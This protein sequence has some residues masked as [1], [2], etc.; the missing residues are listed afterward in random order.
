MSLSLAQRPIMRR[1]GKVMF[2]SAAPYGGA[3]LAFAVSTAFSL[4]L[5]A[6]AAT[7]MPDM[8]SVAIRQSLVRFDTPDNMHGRVS[9]VYAT[10]IGASI[11]LGEFESG[12]ADA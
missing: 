5:V 2:A 4:S 10:F 9:A 12:E 3:T 1:S 11:Q 6:S 8:V 7:C